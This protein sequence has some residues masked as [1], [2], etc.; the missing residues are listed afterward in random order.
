MA[1]PKI[2]KT[3]I[4]DSSAK[5]S[6]DVEI[7]PF[8]IVGSRVKIGKNTKLMSNVLIEETDI[9]QNCVVYPL[10]H[11]AFHPRT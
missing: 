9:G 5:L 3:A 6:E 2:H 1:K 8:C 7:G 4:V 11:S 10:H